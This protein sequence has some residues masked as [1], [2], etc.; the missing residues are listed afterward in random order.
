[1]RPIGA[2]ANCRAPAR[3]TP[4][5]VTSGRQVDRWR[6]RADPVFCPIISPPLEGSPPEGVLLVPGGEGRWGRRGR[7]EGVFPEP[8][9]LKWKQLYR[10]EW[11]L[12]FRHV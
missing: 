12:P 4:D 1:M 2:R 9:S 7:G 8:L 3:W 10:G 6:V 11:G 5:D